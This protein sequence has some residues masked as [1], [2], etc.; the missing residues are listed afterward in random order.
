MAKSNIYSSK[1]EMLLA[2]IGSLT[3]LN[4]TTSK[5]K[6][7]QGNK[8]LKLCLYTSAGRF[9]GTPKLFTDTEIEESQ[10]ITFNENKTSFK[11]NMEHLIKLRNQQIA[12]LPDDYIQTGIPG[13]IYLMDV[14]HTTNNGDQITMPNAYV[15]VDSVVS[16]VLCN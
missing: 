14:T 11:I 13:V 9:I 15:F 16:F 8:P 3:A 2:A 5:V 6:E 12:E 10:P 1:T 7:L 4:D